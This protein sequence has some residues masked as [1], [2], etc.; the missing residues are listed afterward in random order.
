MDTKTP[1]RKTQVLVN[2][3]TLNAEFKRYCQEYQSL[4]IAVAWCSDP[5]Q[6]SVFKLLKSFG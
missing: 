1:T 4:R 5:R 2:S 6:M 3:K